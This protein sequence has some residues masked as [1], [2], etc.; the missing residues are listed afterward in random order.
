[1]LAVVRDRICIEQWES[2]DLIREGPIAV[3]VDGDRV[4]GGIETTHGVFGG[5]IPP[6]PTATPSRNTASCVSRQTVP[7]GG[8][9]TSGHE[10]KFANA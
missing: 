6:P 8:G 7:E 3:R 9:S 10:P 2:E 1:M 4:S 5:A